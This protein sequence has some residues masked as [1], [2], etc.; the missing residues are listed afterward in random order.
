MSGTWGSDGVILL[1]LPDGGIERVSASG[2]ACTQVTK[3]GSVPSRL[4]D[5]KRFIYFRQ[6]NEPDVMGVFLGSIDSKP[7]EQNAT[8]ILRIPVPTRPAKL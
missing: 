8:R 5:G 6:A 3:D 1:S 4:P 2:G 7:D